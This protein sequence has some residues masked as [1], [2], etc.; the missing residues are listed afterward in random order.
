MSVTELLHNPSV[1]LRS[2]YS[3]LWKKFWA[4]PTGVMKINSKKASVCNF[5]AVVSIS[6]NGFCVIFFIAANLLKMWRNHK[7][8]GGI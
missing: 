3:E 5:I 7:S 4:N 2:W 1:I 6:I 8:F